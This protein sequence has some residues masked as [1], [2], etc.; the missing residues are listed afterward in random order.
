MTLQAMVEETKVI[1]TLM[2]TA[3]QSDVKFPLAGEAYS[4]L[5]ALQNE[6]LTN[7]KGMVE[8]YKKRTINRPPRANKIMF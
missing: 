2:Y 7:I 1:T 3:S 6:L 8:D 5:T 4:R